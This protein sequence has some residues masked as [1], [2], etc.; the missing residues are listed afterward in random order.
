[1]KEIKIIISLEQVLI[2]LATTA[3]NLKNYKRWGLVPILPPRKNK[4]ETLEK[5][6]K[7]FWL[8]T[9]WFKMV[10]VMV[11]K[12][13]KWW[14][15]VGSKFSESLADELSVEEP[16]IYYVVLIPFGPGGGFNVQYPAVYVRISDVENNK[17][18]QHV[19]IHEI[20]HILYSMSAKD[21]KKKFSHKEREKIVN[22]LMNRTLR[23]M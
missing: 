7:R 16:P 11:P 18:W 17:W 10:Q 20:S 9:N 3:K 6:A 19:I 14:E 4:K 13:R 22:R 12:I 2:D 21:K 5:A 1:M 8:E 23:K 15:D